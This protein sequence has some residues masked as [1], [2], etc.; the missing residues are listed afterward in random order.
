MRRIG[1]RK[2]LNSFIFAN[3]TAD[4]GDKSSTTVF[5]VANLPLQYVISPS[6][7]V[8]ASFEGY[9]GPTKELEAAIK[10]AK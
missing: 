9:N 4:A 5:Q 8:V 7:K 2:I 6:G 10:N 1:W 3:D